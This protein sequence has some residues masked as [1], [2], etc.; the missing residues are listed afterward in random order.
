MNTATTTRQAAPALVPVALDGRPEGG[1]H[2]ADALAYARDLTAL[3]HRITTAAH[4][5]IADHDA[6]T[7]PATPVLPAD[8]RGIIGLAEAHG[9]DAAAETDT[10]GGITLRV[11]RR[12]DG[13]TA[14]SR[15]AWNYGLYWH[16]L[17]TGGHHYVSTNST[18]LS[19]GC[20]LPNRRPTLE[21]VRKAIRTNPVTRPAA[22]PPQFVVDSDT[23]RHF[24]K[25]VTH[26]NGQPVIR[27]HGHDL[28]ASYPDFTAAARDRDILNRD[29]RRLGD[30]PIVFAGWTA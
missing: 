25:H 6:A 13:D 14:A 16:P 23:G 28:P 8:A 30:E 4:R 22:E 26:G 2:P 17:T 12:R 20:F 3:A 9:W 27:A 15:P 19:P 24:V 18:A 5:A 10:H 1:M 11:T 7:D 29:A 21:A